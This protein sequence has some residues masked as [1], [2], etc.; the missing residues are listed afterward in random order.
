MADRFVFLEH[1]AD[2][3]FEARGKSFT[4]ALENAAGALFAFVGESDLKKSARALPGEANKGSP[5]KAAKAEAKQAGEKLK[6]S[7]SAG[8]ADEL[9]V[10]FLSRLL[11]EMDSAEMVFTK[12]KI[13]DYDEKKHSISAEVWG[14]H[15]RPLRSVKA[16][17]F[18]M[19]KIE[20][21]K[22]GCTIRV[23]LDV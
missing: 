9:V 15:A 22:E 6:I 5:A 23:L 7:E 11:S 4:D 13:T 10:F 12:A 16:V 19:L 1:T 17:T 20:E 3:L 18:H 8:S 2:A 21:K 14:T